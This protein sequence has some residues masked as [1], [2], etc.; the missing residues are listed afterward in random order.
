LNKW[1]EVDQGA[2]VEAFVGPRIGFGVVDAFEFQVVSSLSLE[3][4][5][6]HVFLIETDCDYLTWD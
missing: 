5:A 4:V 3:A 6:N 1:D 2:L